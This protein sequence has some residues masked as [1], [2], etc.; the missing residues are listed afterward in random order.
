MRRRMVLLLLL[1]GG[2]ALVASVGGGVGTRNAR[3][4]SWYDQ[5][6]P[7]QK[8]ILSGFAALEF[9]P[10][11][12][13]SQPVPQLGS[14][15]DEDEDEGPDHV[16]TFP[17]TQKVTCAA[18]FGGN[19]R[20]NQNCLN[21][22]DPDLQGRGEAQNET[23]IASNPNNRRQVVASYN[24]YRRGDGTCGV[25]YSNDGDDHWKDATTPN[26][27]TRGT[28]FGSK[29]REYWQASGDTAVAWDTRGNAYLL[30]QTFMRGSDNR[31]T[32]NP[33]QSSA[34]YLFRSTGSKGASWNFPARPIAEHDDT[35]GVGNALL[36]KPYMTVDNHK[37]SPFR[38]R[39]YVSWTFFA[40]DRTA[41][42]YEAYSDDYGEREV[43]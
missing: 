5:L 29:L 20:V 4:T 43:D 26:G 35:A 14:G 40:P 38:D 6:P 30:C 32:N 3:A 12:P 21:V 16:T 10:N 24:D 7:I 1:A 13:N 37:A 36:D 2:V 22:S 15:G 27:F 11:G 19:V 25:S 41:Y 18:N 42:I 17:L 39:I 34:L 8:R 23:A 28:A 33:D 31:L 9:G